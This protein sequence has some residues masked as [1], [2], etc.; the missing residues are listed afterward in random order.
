MATVNTIPLDPQFVKA[1][2]LLHSKNENAKDQ[3]LQLYQEVVNNAKAMESQKDRKVTVAGSRY[4]E[5]MKNKP[6][7]RP[8]G[9]AKTTVAPIIGRKP[10]MQ[11]ISNNDSKSKDITIRT[12]D[13]SMKGKSTVH[14]D[15][16]WGSSCSVCKKANSNPGNQLVECEECHTRYHQ[17]CHS[18]PV[19]DK[20]VSDLRG[21]WY[22]VSCSERMKEMTT[23]QISTENKQVPNQGSRIS[24]AVQRPSHKGTLS[25]EA[26]ISEFLSSQSSNSG[27]NK[28]S[29][30]STLSQMRPTTTTSA[31]ASRLN[32]ALAT[33]A[34]IKPPKIQL[35]KKPNPSNNN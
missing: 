26:K 16:T 32:S 14:M 17:S 19:A 2:K 20:D 22:C 29:T 27:A 12:D 31:I 15:L 35:L 24:I 3:L 21:V 33:Q 25:F 6:M 4:S 5:Q 8:Y 9:G 18:P 11:S 23:R 30:G 10:T 7:I 28:G 34:S 13:K 1:L